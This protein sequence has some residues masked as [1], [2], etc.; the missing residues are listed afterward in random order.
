MSLPIQT[1]LPFPTRLVGS[2]TLTINA[3]QTIQFLALNSRQLR[4]QFAVCNLDAAITLKL[5]TIFGSIF[6]SVRPGRTI[7]YQTSA[8]MQVF[9]PG[10]APVLFEVCELYPDISGTSDSGLPPSKATAASGGGSASGSYT[11]GGTRGGKIGR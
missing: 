6:G 3:G 7:T 9:N 5:Q 11:G 2:G 10:A 1:F 8:D 4:V